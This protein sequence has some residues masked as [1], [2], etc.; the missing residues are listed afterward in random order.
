MRDSGEV[1]GLTLIVG[2]VFMNAVDEIELVFDA[3]VVEKA[4]DAGIP[5][6]DRD[7]LRRSEE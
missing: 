1:T 3:H 5:G 2:R 7:G 4:I 6:D